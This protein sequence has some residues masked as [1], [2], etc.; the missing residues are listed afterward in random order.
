MSIWWREH[1]DHHMGVLLSADGPFKGC[2]P[3]AGGH[4]TNKLKPLP[5]DLPPE[6][7]FD[8]LGLIRV[9]AFMYTHFDN[10][11]DLGFRRRELYFDFHRKASNVYGPQNRLYVGLTSK[12]RFT[13]VVF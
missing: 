10:A 5:C 4:A 1:A 6:D 8:S 11:R 2:K 9:A 13:N 12:K 7:C 3:V